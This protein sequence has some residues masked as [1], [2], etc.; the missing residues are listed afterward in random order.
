MI[1]TTF[2]FCLWPSF[3][4]ATLSGSAA[5]RA[6]VNS[7]LSITASVVVAFA[8]SRSIHGGLRFDM[9]RAATPF[10]HYFFNY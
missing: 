4:A 7:L 10:P 5:E 9:A 3:N 6:V 8:A 2:L 1:G